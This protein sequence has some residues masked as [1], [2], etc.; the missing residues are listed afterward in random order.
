MGYSTRLRKVVTNRLA[1]IGTALSSRQELGVALLFGGSK[2]LVKPLLV[3]GETTGS[4][5]TQVA[6]LEL[7]EY[8]VCAA[9]FVS[10][11]RR[12]YHASRSESP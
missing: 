2:R 12:R 11:L 8:C 1:V 6:V 3:A 7:A 10:V 9:C 4:S 5:T